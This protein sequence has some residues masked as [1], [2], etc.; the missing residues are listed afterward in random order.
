MGTRALIKIEGINYCALYKHW[1]GAPESTLPW[2][3]EFNKSF[4]ENRGSDGE[5]KMAQ[6]IRSSERDGDKFQLDRNAY[7]G[8]GVVSYDFDDYAYE[9]TLKDDGTVTYKPAWE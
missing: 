4:K 7:T 3:E 2:L 6:L 9:Y 8:W 1:D 5:Y